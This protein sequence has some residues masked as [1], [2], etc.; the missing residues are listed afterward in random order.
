MTPFSCQP[1]V[2]EVEP[3][4]HGS[5]VEGSLDGVELVWCA[6]NF[7]TIWD[8]GALDNG[9]EELGAGFE[10]EGFETTTEGVNEDPPGGIVLSRGLV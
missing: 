10:F 3:S 7:G 4:D 2:V 8:R 9:S 1:A 5:N 6:V